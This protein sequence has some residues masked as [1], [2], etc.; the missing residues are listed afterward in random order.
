MI[1][2][3]ISL[4]IHIRVSV[5]VTG[6]Q[7]ALGFVLLCVLRQTLGTPS[8]CALTQWFVFLTTNDSVAHDAIWNQIRVSDII[9]EFQFVSG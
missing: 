2:Y 3:L 8:M 5:S 9:Y 6:N 7:L 1:F 4:N